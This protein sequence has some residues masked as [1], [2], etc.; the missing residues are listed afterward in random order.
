MEGGGRRREVVRRA[1]GAVN[2]VIDKGKGRG[3]RKRREEEERGRG[4]RRREEGEEGYIQLKLD[5][6]ILNIHHKCFAI[7]TCL[8][9]DI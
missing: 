5:K 2:Y 1:Y 3:G 6:A 9:E 7:P 4:K 8:Q